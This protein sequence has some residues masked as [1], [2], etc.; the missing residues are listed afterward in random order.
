MQ[1]AIRCAIVHR[2]A[3]L[4]SWLKAS[5]LRLGHK[6]VSASA[7]TEEGFQRACLLRPDL[8]LVEAGAAEGK[9]GNEGYAGI[10]MMRDIRRQLPMPVIYI[11]RDLGPKMIE[12]ARPTRPL[13]FLNRP[14]RARDLLGMLEACR[15]ERSSLPSP[16]EVREPR[17]LAGG[18]RS[19]HARLCGTLDCLS[20]GVIIVLRDM[21][22]EYANL[23][24][25]RILRRAKPLAVVAGRLCLADTALER[26]LSHLVRHSSCG[27]LTLAVEA[28]ALPE[29]RI[30]LCPIPADE[31]SHG[32]MALYLTD[33]RE[34]LQEIELQLRR[35]HRLTRA[36]SRVVRALLVR[37]GR[38]AVA[39]QLF[40]SPQ[41]VGTHLQNI[42][43]KL[44]VHNQQEL[45][46]YIVTGPVGNLL[47]LDGYLPLRQEAPPAD[48]RLGAGGE[49][50][51]GPA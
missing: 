34:Q 14:L 10:G 23:M 22:L 9:N 20:V 31:L 38:A 42:Y 29:L 27:S 7:T 48:A 1:N 26:R 30:L 44:D 46:H 3:G 17:P 41:T 47:R 40:I 13:G 8:M 25:R 51:A 36:E 2:S 4:R 24:G 35:F 50:A 12:A 43:G 49:V 11:A 21:R 37:P 19:L 18:T 6:V 5:L 16:P 45:I 39:E 32:A 15:G 28:A 33:P